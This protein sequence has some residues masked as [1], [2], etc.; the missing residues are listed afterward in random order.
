MKLFRS[1]NRLCAPLIAAV[2]LLPFVPRSVGAAAYSL[3]V[4]PCFEHNFYTQ[5]GLR[6]LFA[7]D[8]LLRRHPQ[9]GVSYTTSR[10]G[11]LA[12]RN[13]LKKDNVLLSASWHFRPER[14]IDPHAG[15]DIGFT[16][17]DRESDDLF[18]LL[19]NRAPMF[20]LRVGIASALLGGRLRAAVDGG[21]ALAQSSTVFPL[22]IGAAVGIDL[23]KGVLP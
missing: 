21:I 9:I 17:F 18:A 1:H 20:N 10:L 16:R 3:Q 11:A 2:L 14:M 22:F 6:A 12:G 13:V 19:E 4:G 8:L 5:F 23:A 15:I 7:H